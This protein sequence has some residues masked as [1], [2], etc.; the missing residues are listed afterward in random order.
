MQALFLGKGNADALT[1]PWSCSTNRVS[2]EHSTSLL[3]ILEGKANSRTIRAGML[4]ASHG[5]R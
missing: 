3:K 5:Q 1:S 4:A 2:L